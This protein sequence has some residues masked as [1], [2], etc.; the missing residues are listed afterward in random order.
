MV[1]IKVKVKIPNDSL[2][3]IRRSPDKIIIDFILFEELSQKFI[4]LDK[5]D[6]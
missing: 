1:S 3:I 6:C 2:L 4:N 5:T